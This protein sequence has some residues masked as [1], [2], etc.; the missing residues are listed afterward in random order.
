MGTRDESG[1]GFVGAVVG[2][3]YPQQLGDM[4]KAMPESIILIP[5]FGAQ[6]AGAKHVARGFDR[7]GKGAIV[8]SSR[9]LM[10]AWKSGKLS[11]KYRHSEFCEAAREEAMRMR[12]EI[13][14]ALKP[15]RKSE[16]I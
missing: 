3:T 15:G 12:D 11:K 9:G 7:D 5:G 13:N 2:G 14:Q 8:N 4:R 10:N 6:G 1:Y 16:T